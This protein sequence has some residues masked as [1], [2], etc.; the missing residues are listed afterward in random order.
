MIITIDRNEILQRVKMITAYL[1]VNHHDAPQIDDRIAAADSDDDILNTFWLDACEEACEC[2]RSW[3]MPTM[4][5]TSEEGRGDC[6]KAVLSFPLRVVTMK[7]T[8]ITMTLK[9]MMTSSILERWTAITT[10]EAEN[11]YATEKESWRNLL[12]R[13]LCFKPHPRRLSTI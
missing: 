4:M 3:L 1:A 12:A 11:R 6:L 10:P 13:L 5:E 7:Q 2:L 9:A 8:S